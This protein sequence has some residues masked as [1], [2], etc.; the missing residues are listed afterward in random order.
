MNDLLKISQV[1]ERLNCSTAFVY[2]LMDTG[3]LKYFRLARTGLRVSEQQLADYLKNCEEGGQPATE[4]ALPLK[5]I[6]LPS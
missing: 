5:H 3:R 6:K 2:S 1:K 4:P